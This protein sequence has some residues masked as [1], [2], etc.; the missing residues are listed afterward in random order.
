MG[1]LGATLAALAA[2]EREPV[3]KQITAPHN[4]YYREMYLP[5]AQSGPTAPAWSP[6][7]RSLVA[8]MQGSL[9]LELA[10]DHEPALILLDLHLPDLRGE[11]VLLQLKAD[12]RT[13]EIPV[14]VLSAD[15]TKGQIERL[16]ASG[17]HAYLT[18]PLDLK[19]LLVL[20]DEKLA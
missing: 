11:E 2:A 20:F 10:R 7:G 9:G 1:T 6:D 14:I 17:A 8:A 3:L 19:Q 4:Y 16:L 5:Q 12:S 15:A 13:R 18:K